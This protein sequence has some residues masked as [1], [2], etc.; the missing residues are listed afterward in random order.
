[1]FLKLLKKKV[2]SHREKIVVIST[3]HGLKFVEFK[4]G[5]HRSA[6]EGISSDLKN[7]PVE[8]PNDYKTVRDAIQSRISVQ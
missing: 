4:A 2:I 8:L 3:A 5:Y 7:I 6:L 1:M